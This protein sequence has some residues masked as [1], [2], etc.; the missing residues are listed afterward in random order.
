MV[1]IGERRSYYLLQ[2]YDPEFSE[3]FK[4]AADFDDRIPRN[5]EHVEQLARW[6]AA[7]V[8]RE[9]LRHLNRAGVARLVEDSARSSG[10]AERLSAGLHR[11]IDLVREAHYLAGRDGNQRIGSDD[12][13][14]AIDA[15]GV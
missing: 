9:G 5:S 7:T 15:R 3:L 2:Q 14:A 13:Q 6:L 12:I 4:V 8:R 10:D 11:A 1:L